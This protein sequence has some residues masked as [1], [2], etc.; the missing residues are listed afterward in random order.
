MELSLRVK[1]YSCRLGLEGSRA[2]SLAVRVPRPLNRNFLLGNIEAL[3]SKVCCV[4]KLL[5]IPTH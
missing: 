3:A 1:V 2:M 5:S 4:C